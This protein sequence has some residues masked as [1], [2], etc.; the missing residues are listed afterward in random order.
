ME[1]H[2][3]NTTRLQVNHTATCLPARTATI[4]LQ[5]SSHL[6]P[7]LNSSQSLLQKFSEVEKQTSSSQFWWCPVPGK[8]THYLRWI[9]HPEIQ[10][11]AGNFS[12]STAAGNAN[13]AGDWFLTFHFHSKELKIIWT[14]E[15]SPLKG[16]VDLLTL[17]QWKDTEVALDRYLRKSK[18]LDSRYLL[19]ET[20]SSFWGT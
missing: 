7:S 12:Q 1:R 2:S 19:L 17:L 6:P 5:T 18:C 20:A 4:R 13:W 14:N 3:N 9:T 8:L 16:S 15:K 10:N 11:T